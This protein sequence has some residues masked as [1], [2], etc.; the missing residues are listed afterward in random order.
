MGGKF[1]A[2]AMGIN[3]PWWLKRKPTPRA[4]IWIAIQ[5]IKGWL[6]DEGATQERVYDVAWAGDDRLQSDGT[7]SR[8]LVI[9]L[10]W[11]RASRRTPLVRPACV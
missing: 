1:S 11:Q 6:D 8:P 10:I 5:V 2:R 9:R 4:G 3:F 7:P